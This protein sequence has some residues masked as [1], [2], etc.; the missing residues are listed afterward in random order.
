MWIEGILE[1]KLEVLH[2]WAN[3]VLL[4]GHGLTCERVLCFLICRRDSTISLCLSRKLPVRIGSH[5]M[6]GLFKKENDLLA[7]VSIKIF[8]AHNRNI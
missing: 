8:I 6:N 2:P 4:D 1:S 7:D 5:F 3:Q